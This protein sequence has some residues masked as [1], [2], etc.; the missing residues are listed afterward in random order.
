MPLTSPGIQVDRE[1]SPLEPF[2]PILGTSYYYYLFPP[3]QDHSADIGGVEID[4]EEPPAYEII[5][6]LE[7]TGHFD[8]LAHEDEDIYALDDGDPVE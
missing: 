4:A 5:R 7:Q 6:A 8:Y 2:D 1:K 3:R